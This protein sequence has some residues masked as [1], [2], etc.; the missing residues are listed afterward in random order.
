MLRT[1][2]GKNECIITIDLFIID[3]NMFLVLIAHSFI[4][5]IE[6]SELNFNL[7]K[8]AKLQRIH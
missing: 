7:T 3:E 1:L 8:P 2:L 6:V 4:L 5:T